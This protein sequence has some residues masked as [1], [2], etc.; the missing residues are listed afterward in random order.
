MRGALGGIGILI[1]FS[2]GAMDAANAQTDW[3]TRRHDGLRTGLQPG[4]GALANR[5]LLPG[6]R[7]I[8]SAPPDE[9]CGSAQAWPPGAPT[10]GTLHASPIIVKRMAFI[11]RDNGVFCAATVAETITRTGTCKSGQTWDQTQRRCVDGGLDSN[12]RPAPLGKTHCAAGSEWGLG[13]GE[14]PRERPTLPKV[15]PL[16]PRGTYFS[17][18]KK[19]C[20]AQQPAIAH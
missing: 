14:C 6:V 7:R 13:E 1:L 19:A 2:I 17:D 3:P 11:V 20:V 9:N 15:I 4:V 5:S 10:P 12:T 18:F 8:W 16:C